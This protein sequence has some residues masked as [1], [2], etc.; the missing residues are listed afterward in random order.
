MSSTTTKLSF[1]D[2]LAALVDAHGSAKLR[3][4][5]T[6]PELPG[7]VEDAIVGATA[8][9]LRNTLRH[10][11][12][13]TVVVQVETNK[14]GVWVRV[15][16]NGPGMGEGTRAGFGLTHSINERMLEVDGTVSVKTDP[17]TGTEIGLNWYPKPEGGLHDAL[18][19][20]VGRPRRLVGLFA[21]PLML[22]SWYLVFRYGLQ[23]GSK[24]VTFAVAITTSVIAVAVITAAGTR[25]VPLIGVVAMVCL[26][27]LN[28]IGLA[29]AG[30][31]AVLSFRSWS[32]GMTGNVALAMAASLPP[33]WPLF[34][35]IGISA[36]TWWAAVVDPTVSPIE[37]IGAILQTLFFTVAGLLVARSIL[38][39]WR[40]TSQAFDLARHSRAEALLAAVNELSRAEQAER[41]GDDLGDFLAA[42]AVDLDLA[43]PK[44]KREASVLAARVRDELEQP[45]AWPAAVREELDSARRRGAIVVVRSTAP[46]PW[47]AQA[48][49]LIISLLSA[50]T[51]EQ[52]TITIRANEESISVRGVVKP[53]WSPRQSDSL[54]NA[55]TTQG[56][57]TSV[58]IDTD[59][60]AT[61]VDLN[62]L[63]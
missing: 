24:T 53:P 13:S 17:N 18:V 32:I 52:L 44:V 54:K 50:T 6:T 35:A 51:T 22:G 63:R 40:G 8:E 10:A 26:P 46:A 9:A 47:P 3:A 2:R 55:V 4:T 7:Q 43:D 56:L 29:N 23:D 27:I 21:L 28:A 25:W 14:K 15:R 30:D 42:A 36:T 19:D 39:A 62:E 34:A 58:A 60:D 33:T 45:G 16:D 11:P 49:R 5:G 31:G 41:L 38:L 57:A 12:G 20:M 48:N 59:D 37:A 1:L 61:L